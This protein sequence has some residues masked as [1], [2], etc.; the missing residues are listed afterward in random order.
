MSLIFTESFAAFERLTIADNTAEGAT[1][2]NAMAANLRRGGYEVSI[3]ETLNDGYRKSGFF[4]RADP[5]APERSALVNSNGNTIGANSGS[6]N[7][8]GV[9]NV[10]RLLPSTG[11]A[12]IGGFSLYIPQEYVAPLTAAQNFTT[13]IFRVNAAPANATT[14]WFNQGGAAG[15]DGALQIFQVRAD[16]LVSML[17]LNQSTKALVPGRLNY[18]EF[19]I[20][21]KDV[22]VWLDDVLV[23]QHASQLVPES[24]CFSFDQQNM[25]APATFARNE[26]GRWAISNF[27]VLAEDAIAPNVRLGPTTRVIGVRPS[28]D[29]DVDFQRPAGFDT[30]AQI[31]A[32]NLVDSPVAALQ[33]TQVGDMDIYATALD[34]ATPNAKLVHA[35]AT[36]V[37]AANLDSTAHTVRSLV[38]SDT[39]VE[40]VDAKVRE[41]KIVP[42]IVSPLARTFRDIARRPTDNKIFMCGASE[43]LYVTPPNGKPGS[44]WSMVTDNGT[45]TYYA[46]AFRADGTGIVT[47]ADSK[48]QVIPPGSDT[49]G[50]VL[51]P[52]A[53]TLPTNVIIDGAIAMPDGAF[54]ITS[55]GGHFFRCAGDPSV[56]ANWTRGTFPATTNVLHRPVYAVNTN[57][58]VVFSITTA[59]LIWTSNDMGI[60]WT[61][62]TSGGGVIPQSD[63]TQV[64]SDGSSF[65]FINQIT[66]TAGYMRYSTDG[67]N[68]VV[69]GTT[70]NSLG[71]S[72]GGVVQ[73]VYGSEGTY[74]VIAPTGNSWFT[75]RNPMEGLRRLTG[76]ATNT[77]NACVA[78]NGDIMFASNGGVQLAYTSQ[79]FDMAMPAL[80]GYKMAYNASSINPD[81]GLP[82]TTTE[83]TRAQ[84]GLRIT[85]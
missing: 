18:L 57:I 85:S 40:R 69:P 7:T 81:T 72:N 14:T 26:A 33:S 58:L 5:V 24:I 38:R 37:V 52:G 17:A 64:A 30:N 13:S 45:V 61:A 60:T 27:Y 80:S 54:I 43:A 78:F 66:N 70:F 28:S 35:V 48:I 59:N 12:I 32:Q 16:L 25:A 49:P 6:T 19:R 84:F 36:K 15:A 41:L 62:R 55:R 73:T 77:N 22:R 21:D 3:N 9:A 1:A 34:T 39:G 65:Y 68:W 79:E 82:W 44:P 63:R 50:P 31:A 4:V 42:G 46:I 47:R 53:A 71:G 8:H 75:T 10:R 56:P 67:I 20:T 29:T 2:R 76:D 51:N 83:A 11:H 23:L 74:I